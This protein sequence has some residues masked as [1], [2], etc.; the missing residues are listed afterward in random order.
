MNII[1]CNDISSKLKNST[2]ETGYYSYT[3][4]CTQADKENNSHICFFNKNPYRKKTKNKRN[5]YTANEK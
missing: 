5:C 4:R 1:V 2:S 3:N